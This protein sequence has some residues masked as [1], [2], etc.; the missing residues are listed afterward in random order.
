[1]QAATVTVPDDYPSIQWAIDNATEGDTIVVKDGV[2]VENIVVNK[3]L[4][5]KSENGF[6]NCIVKAGFGNVITITADYA[7]I[8]GFT[9]AGAGE[10]EFLFAGI[11]INANHC[12]ITDN[13][14]L[15][16]SVGIALYGANDNI[17][18]NNN[19]TNNIFGVRLYYSNNNLVYLNNFINVN[20]VYSYASSNLWNSPEQIIYQYSGKTFINYLGNYW[21]DYRDDEPS[22]FAGEDLPPSGYMPLNNYL[23][24]DDD[25]VGDISYTTYTDSDKDY[26]PLM[27]PFE[28]Y[29]VLERGPELV[30][31]E[32]RNLW[33]GYL[34][35]MESEKGRLAVEFFI[36]TRI[37]VANEVNYFWSLLNATISHDEMVKNLLGE[38]QDDSGKRVDSFEMNKT[39]DGLFSRDLVGT[40]ALSVIYT[41]ASFFG[42]DLPFYNLPQYYWTNVMMTDISSNNFTY[43]VGEKLPITNNLRQGICKLHLA[44]SM[45]E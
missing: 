27:K 9:F 23:D 3:R 35:Q 44:N 25:G 13:L 12:R 40:N 2:Y 21:N 41:I 20:N 22:E 31:Y 14:C 16:N 4:T 5:I 17:I 15:N 26:Y 8:T 29:F 19:I 24:L 42:V 11:S 1:L 39:D 6:D 33:E 30:D 45:V 34:K 43:A 36:L 7:S 18:A 38:I 32:I 28:N 10:N 37:L